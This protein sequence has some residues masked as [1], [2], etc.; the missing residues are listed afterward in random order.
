VQNDP[1]GPHIGFVSHR[2]LLQ[3]FRCHEGECANAINYMLALFKLG[4][5]T[6]VSNFDPGELGIVRAEDILVF[7]ITMHHSLL[8][9][10]VDPN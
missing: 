2:L 9:Y 4:G 7:E 10:I 8:M 1:K 6:E 3:N 5:K